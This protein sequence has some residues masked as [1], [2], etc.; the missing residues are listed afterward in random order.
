MRR[1]YW[2]YSVVRNFEKFASCSPS[3]GGKA[4]FLVPRGWERPLQVNLPVGALGTAGVSALPLP[5]A[6]VLQRISTKQ[7][8]VVVRG[9][10]TSG[11]WLIGVH[12]AKR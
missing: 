5:F 1:F 9:T 10:L 3:N 4:R 2:L 8:V 12:R 6:T 11:E 7:L